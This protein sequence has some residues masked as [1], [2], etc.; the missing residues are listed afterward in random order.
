MKY[1]LWIQKNVYSH[2]EKWLRNGV[3][4]VATGLDPRFQEVYLLRLQAQLLGLADCVEKIKASC[5]VCGKS[6]QK[7]I[8]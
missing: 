5:T 2:V 1:S 7:L 4:V 3:N 6:T 8:E